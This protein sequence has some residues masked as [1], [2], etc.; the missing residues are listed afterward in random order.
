MIAT[1]G[2]HK[3]KLIGGGFIEDDR[4]EP[5]KSGGL[6]MN[7]VCAGSFQSKI[8]TIAGE[9]SIISKT[10][11]VITKFDLVV[12]VVVA[13]VSENY[14]ALAV[15]FKAGTGHDIEHAIGAVAVVRGISPALY[16]EIINILRI[17]L[18]SDVRRNACIRH[19]HSIDQPG[20]LV[21]PA[22]V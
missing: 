5:A 3:A 18:R 2:S 9:A 15:T 17:E 7:N 20:N 4:A 19:W 16:F 14:F 1:Q 10:F 21:A 8:G 13:A 12:G 6:I 22:N 11:G